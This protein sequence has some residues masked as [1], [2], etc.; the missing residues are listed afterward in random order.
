MILGNHH[1]TNFNDPDGLIF[2]LATLGPGFLREEI[3][4]TLTPLHT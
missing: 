4:L 3:T 2:E 1:N